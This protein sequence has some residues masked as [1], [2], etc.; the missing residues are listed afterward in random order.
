[1][2]IGE[3]A[4]TESRN[5]R[6]VIL[7][8]GDHVSFSDTFVRLIGDEFSH[9]QV[10]CN[11]RIEWAERKVQ[12]DG[13]GITLA[14]VDSKLG[15]PALAALQRIA[16][17]APNIRPVL[18]YTSTA[19]IKSVLSLVDD[20][21][22]ID[23]VSFLPMRTS[24][25]AILSIIHL[26]ISGECHLSNDVVQLL[27]ESHPR[28]IPETARDHDPH[29]AVTGAIRP[30]QDMQVDLDMLT[31]REQEVLS[32]VSEGQPNK[33]IAEHLDLSPSTVKLHIHHII[34]KLGVRN[35]T[36]AAVAYLG[37]SLGIRQDSTT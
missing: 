7:F 5:D 23:R 13:A 10:I 11:R 14:V 29:D 22:S 1:M 15:P 2:K 4:P 25:D 28:D 35:R 16:R 31:A 24:I 3:F 6:P 18:A 34:A 12:T 19:E 9:F 21:T 30:V 26:L 8:I 36:E 20:Y 17:T 33:K 37:S 32:L 27:L